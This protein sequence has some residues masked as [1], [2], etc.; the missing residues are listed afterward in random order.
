VK[1]ILKAKT[2][3]GEKALMDHIEERKHFSLKDKFFGSLLYSEKCIS[4][5]PYTT[6]ISIPDK[7]FNYLLQKNAVYFNA[8]LAE[9]RLQVKKELARFGATEKD[10]SIEVT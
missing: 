4:L 7:G 2:K 8:A 1:I 5:D 9:T 3:K 10:Y 6:E